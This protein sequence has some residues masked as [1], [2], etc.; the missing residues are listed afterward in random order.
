[1]RD[2]MRWHPREI[3]NEIRIEGAG[4]V[5]A[6]Q[7]ARSARGVS[8]KIRWKLFT[9]QFIGIP[10]PRVGNFYSGRPP[11]LPP[12]LSPSLSLSLSLSLSRSLSV[13]CIFF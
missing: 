11:S 10:F 13:G 12:S 3:G 8:C 4:K 2:S 7:H 1:M 6:R 5:L 9:G